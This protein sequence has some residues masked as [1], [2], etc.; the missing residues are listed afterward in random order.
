MYNLIRERLD[1]I[2][3]TQYW[4][5]KKTGICE[6][7]VSRTITDG[8]APSVYRAIV[9]AHALGCQVEDIFIVPGINISRPRGGGSRSVPD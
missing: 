3:K 8:R 6:T 9:I 5:A 7:V 4:L 2:K 1:K